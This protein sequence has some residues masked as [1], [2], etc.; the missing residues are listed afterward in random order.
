MMFDEERLREITERV[1]EI[2]DRCR[3]LPMQELT[4]LSTKDIR[5]G[6]SPLHINM[7]S[8]SLLRHI[9]AQSCHI[10]KLSNKIKAGANPRDYDAHFFDENGILVKSE[11][12]LG[13]GENLVT[14]YISRDFHVT[15]YNVMGRNYVHCAEY[16]EYDG[17]ILMKSE[18]I[19]VRS[20]IPKG[21]EYYGEYYKYGNNQLTSAEKIENC[22]F[23]RTPEGYIPN[24]KWNSFVQLYDF[25][26]NNG[27][28]AAHVT[29]GKR[30]LT[31]KEKDIDK[32][33]N[34]GVY[35]FGK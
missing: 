27:S 21:I 8:C 15:Y 22:Y 2:F 6:K 29:P 24:T 16:N 3:P 32:L 14:V 4:G 13:D 31:L 34:N 10:K 23:S 11:Y 1:N 30:V 12:D 9:D 33:K 17:D 7:F 19:Q 5:Y 26:Y 35:C 28:V 18:R 25:Q 20:K